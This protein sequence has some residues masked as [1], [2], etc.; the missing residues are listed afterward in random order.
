MFASFHRS[1]Q[2]KLKKKERSNTHGNTE[3]KMNRLLK[4][5]YFEKEK[6]QHSMPHILFSSL[7]LKS[8]KRMLPF[9]CMTSG[10]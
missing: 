3:G 2:L 7:K 6:K 5:D 10:T 4:N 8:K 1:A 9:I